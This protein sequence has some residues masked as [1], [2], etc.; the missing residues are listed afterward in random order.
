M[1]NV[2]LDTGKI[3]SYDELCDACKKY[4]DDWSKKTI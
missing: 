1:A 3:V 2:K 4:W